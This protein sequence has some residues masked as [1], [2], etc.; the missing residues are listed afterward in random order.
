MPRRASFR[1]STASLRAILDSRFCRS[2]RP[3]PTCDPITK[4]IGEPF[5]ISDL[6]TLHE[7]DP[8]AAVRA[9]TDRAVLSQAYRHMQEVLAAEWASRSDSAP[10]D[11]P[12]EALILASIIGARNDPVPLRSP[13]PQANPK[14][15][16]PGDFGALYPNGVVV[17]VEGQRFTVGPREFC[18]NFSCSISWISSAVSCRAFGAVLAMILLFI[19]FCP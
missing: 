11:S 7:Q 6:R 10:V 17:E 13:V 12:Y 3:C 19:C 2:T 1:I 18:C 9:L 5:G 4:V 15:E 16:P 8:V 14:D